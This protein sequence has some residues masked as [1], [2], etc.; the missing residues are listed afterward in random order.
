MTLTGTAL[1][2]VNCNNTT[3]GSMWAGRPTLSPGEFLYLTAWQIC[4]NAGS[5][6]PSL[7]YLVDVIGYY[8]GVNPNTT[9]TQTLTG[10]V[11]LRGYDS[12][13]ATI[14]VTSATGSGTPDVT[15]NYTN[16]ANQTNRSSTTPTFGS[17]NVHGVMQRPF[18]LNLQ[19]TDVG[20]RSVQTITFSTAVSGSCV[21]MLFRPLATIPLHVW[22]MATEREFLSQ[23]PALPTIPADACLAVMQYCGST[24]GSSTT[25]FGNMFFV[26][27]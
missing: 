7:F 5:S 20:I 13:F 2:F 6:Q 8:A 17:V 19:S 1:Q 3:A 24:Q 27:G 18:T 9:A 15:I 26:K 14:I 16:Q 11:N 12:A 22:N 4:S 23:I 10:T 21:L 25:V